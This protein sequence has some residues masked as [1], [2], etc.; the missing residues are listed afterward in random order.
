MTYDQVK[1][2]L[3]KMRFSPLHDYNDK[4]TYFEALGIFEEDLESLRQIVSN[5]WEFVERKRNPDNNFL[6]IDIIPS[7]K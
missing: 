4:G 2:V 5:D 6:R 7:R 3:D 1:T